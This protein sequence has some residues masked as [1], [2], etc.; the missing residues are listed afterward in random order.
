MMRHYIDAAHATWASLLPLVEFAINDSW[1]ESI[2]A[3][4]FEVNYGK[5]PRLP[6]DNILRGEGRV[7]T[8]CD[9]A[10]ER[11]EYILAAV[12]KAKSAMQAAQQR[13]KHIA[14]TKRRPLEFAVGDKVFLST[15]NI[16]LKFKGSPKLLPKWLGP[17]KVT[18][19]INPVAYRL[20]LPNS[21]KLHNVF[22]IS[23]L[24][25]ARDRPGSTTIPPP[26][27]ELI[28]GE[29]EFEVESILSHRFLRNNKTEF[30][31]KWLGY[32][33]EHNTWEPEANCANCPD[34]VTEYWDRVKSQ[35]SAQ[36]ATAQ[37]RTL[38]KRKAGNQIIPD[39]ST[40]IGSRRSLRRRH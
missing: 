22:H 40:V 17:F 30:L 4:P 11:A 9:S 6:L 10:S 3:T 25:A 15:I 21:L 39:T 34:K 12:K 5:R 27:P 35:Q 31:V 26:P 13:Q 32:G 23:L 1:H 37:R 16:K 14:D 28:E 24:K 2:Q 7:V 18:Q 8:N 29:W 19:V 20:E 38:R 36:Q 33:P